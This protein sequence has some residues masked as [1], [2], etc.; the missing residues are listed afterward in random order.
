[1]LF[2]CSSGSVGAI[3]E[4]ARPF[5]PRLPCLAQCACS[6]LPTVL[7]E[8]YHAKTIHSKIAF[9]GA[10][11]FLQ[12][13]PAI[14]MVLVGGKNVIQFLLL[15]FFCQGNPFI[16]VLPL[17]HCLPACHSLQDCRDIL[18]LSKIWSIL[19]TGCISQW[20]VHRTSPRNPHIVVFKIWKAN[21]FGS[22]GYLTI[23]SCVKRLTFM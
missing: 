3:A 7:R 12:I 16:P 22:W 17:E 4:C 2:S 13:R 1:M 5:T 15:A 9:P 20:A 14:R 19:S 6:R 21:S 18:S 23:R 10:L 11:G 8:S